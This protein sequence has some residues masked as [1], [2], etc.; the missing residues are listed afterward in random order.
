MTRQKFI[1]SRFHPISLSQENI[2]AEWLGKKLIFSISKATSFTN[3]KPTSMAR[4]PKVNHLLKRQRTV[5]TKFLK[6]VDIESWYNPYQWR[7]KPKCQNHNSIKTISHQPVC[8]ASL[9]RPECK[10]PKFNIDNLNPNQWGKE[11]K[12]KCKK[13]HSITKMTS[14][15]ISW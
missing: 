10:N 3:W 11:P 4:L 5:N 6:Q 15:P 14:T 9:P 13:Y 7:P 2:N 12:P 8:Q 1:I